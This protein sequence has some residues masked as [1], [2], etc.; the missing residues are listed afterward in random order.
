MAAVGQLLL[1]L[2]LIAQRVGREAAYIPLAVFFV[3]SLLTCALPAIAYLWPDIDL[4]GLAVVLPSFLIQPVALWFYV[5]ALTSPSRWR[6]ERKHLWHL[7]PF[8]AGLIGSLGL[9]SLPRAG[10]ENLF[11]HQAEPDSAFATVVIIYAFVLI[12]VWIFQS[13]VYLFLVFNQLARYRR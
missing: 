2:S 10:L 13:A 9:L 6:P 5:K 12:L 3:A 11:I 1:T 4:Y 8:A 7:L